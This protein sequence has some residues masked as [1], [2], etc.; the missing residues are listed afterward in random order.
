MDEDPKM[1]RSSKNFVVV[2]GGF[3]VIG[4]KDGRTSGRQR[5]Y[6]VR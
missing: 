6:G 3:V 4:W 5:V 1:H 2:V